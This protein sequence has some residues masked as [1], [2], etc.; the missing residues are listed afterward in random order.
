MCKSMVQYFEHEGLD[1]LNVGTSFFHGHQ[2]VQVSD[3]EY[4]RKLMPNGVKL[5]HTQ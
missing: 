4:R 1:T 2:W 5:E 3:S